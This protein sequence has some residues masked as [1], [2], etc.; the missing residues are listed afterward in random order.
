MNSAVNQR[1]SIL[2]SSVVKLTILLMSSFNNDT[3][4]DSVGTRIVIL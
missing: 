2:D 4:R 1:L 3:G